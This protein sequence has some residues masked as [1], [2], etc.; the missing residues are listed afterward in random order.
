MN[1]FSQMIELAYTPQGMVSLEAFV[2]AYM[3]TE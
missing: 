1:L 2:D 3:E